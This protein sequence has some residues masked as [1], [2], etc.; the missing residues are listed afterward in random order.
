MLTCALEELGC[1]TTS[2]DQILAARKSVQIRSFSIWDPEGKTILVNFMRITLSLK[3]RGSNKK[4]NLTV[5]W[6]WLMKCT[7]EQG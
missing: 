4:K 2:L 6:I 1:E 5:I 7:L 3:E